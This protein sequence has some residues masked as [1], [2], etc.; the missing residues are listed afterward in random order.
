MAKRKK[1]RGKLTSAYQKARNNYLASVRYYKKVAKQEGFDIDF[2][3]YEAESVKQPQKVTEGSLRRLHSL[4][5][6]LKKE[7]HS[8]KVKTGWFTR[9]REFKSMNA[10]MR[11]KA[12][13]KP[14][15]DS[16]KK[17][18]KKYKPNIVNQTSVPNYVKAPSAPP[19]LSDITLRTFEQ[20]ARN[21]Q[22]FVAKSKP[23]ED[24]VRNA[25]SDASDSFSSKLSELITKYLNMLNDK[26]VRGK[27]SD[28]LLENYAEYM[29]N[30][31][32]YCFEF[33]Y[34]EMSHTFSHTDVA[35]RGFNHLLQAGFD[36]TLSPEEIKELTDLANQSLDGNFHNY[37]E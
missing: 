2:S 31:E 4:K 28:N 18:S 21:F 27:V 17:S 19:K 13:V 22:T 24:A 36:F 34:D 10:I 29:D 23:Y 8:E 26:E 25:A 3:K 30:L 15:D 6:K 16:K 9:Q 7:V 37:K 11:A 33:W 1:S 14:V 20:T 12:K 5:E 35:L 32:R